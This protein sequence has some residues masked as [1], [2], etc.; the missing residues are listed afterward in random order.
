MI[1][2]VAERLGVPLANVFANQILFDAAVSALFSMAFILSSHSFR[3]RMYFFP[4]TSL[5]NASH[6]N[7]AS[8]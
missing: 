6:E 8:F 5:I 2:P 4:F 7:L 3:I 1:N